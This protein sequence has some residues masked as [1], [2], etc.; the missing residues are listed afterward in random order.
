[1]EF[2]FK[3]ILT[4]VIECRQHEVNNTIEVVRDRV[5]AEVDELSQIVAEFLVVASPRHLCTIPA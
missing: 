1:M 5:A 2:D 4:K 3:S